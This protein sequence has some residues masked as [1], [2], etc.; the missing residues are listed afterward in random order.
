MDFESAKKENLKRIQRFEDNLSNGDC[1]DGSVDF[2][3]RFIQI[4][5]TTRCNAR[6]IMCN[7]LYT[8][9]RGASDLD[10]RVLDAVE[11]ALPY[12]ETVMIN[13][14]GE[15]LLYGKL[16]KSL[17]LFRRYGVSVG[18]NTN[19]SVID[20][21]VWQYFAR[22]FAFLNVSCDGSTKELYEHIRKG[23]SY[24]R[25]VENLNKLNEVAPSLRKHLDCVLMRQNI[26]D[27]ESMVE[28]A[29]RHGFNSVRFHALGVNPVIANDADAPHLY[30]DYLYE[31]A[32]RARKR[33]KELGIG[34]LLPAI[35]GAGG[36]NGEDEL[37]AQKAEAESRERIARVEKLEGHEVTQHL[38]ERVEKSDLSPAPFEHGGACR[39][40]VERCYIDTKGYMTTCCYNVEKRF[41]DLS[42]ESFS[43]VWNGDDYKAFRKQM[44]AGRLPAWCGS[45]EWLK[46]PRF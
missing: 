22:D 44:C 30:P 40:A 6:C 8:A 21:G 9:N 2:F 15:P 5:H 37:R 35:E 46:N 14:D 13:G 27:M 12:A 34:I 1:G 4:E 24:D 28:F 33:A 11:E 41:G 45:C 38:C 3:P 17:S 23:L 31:N 20:G 16:D 42:R 18:T 19:L 7:H 43:G 25:F 39:W 10:D 36:Q 29:H 32:Q 26:S